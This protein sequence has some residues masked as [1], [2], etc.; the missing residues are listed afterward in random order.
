MTAGQLAGGPE[1]DTY[2]FCW[3]GL[4][5]VPPPVIRLE[6]AKN[7]RREVSLRPLDVEKVILPR[8]S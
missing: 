4:V 2:I 3:W 1:S 8:D 5:R 6:D 7:V